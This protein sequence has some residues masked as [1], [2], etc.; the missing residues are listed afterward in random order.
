MFL[1]LIEYSSIKYQNSTGKPGPQILSLSKEGRGSAMGRERL[2]FG[3]YDYPT[4][5]YLWLASGDPL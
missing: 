3:K 5:S 4:R 2:L 1:F